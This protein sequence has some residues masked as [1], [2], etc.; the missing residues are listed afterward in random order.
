M[1]TTVTSVAVKIL[2]ESKMLIKMIVWSMTTLYATTIT[3][4]STWKAMVLIAFSY[5]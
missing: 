5:I 1:E 2:T 3:T 4:G